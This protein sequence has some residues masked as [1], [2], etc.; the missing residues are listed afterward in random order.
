MS[1]DTVGPRGASPG[2]A[3]FTLPPGSDVLFTPRGQTLLGEIAASRTTGKNALQIGTWL[4]AQGVAPDEAAVLLSQAELRA[5]AVLK[6][7]SDAAHLLFTPAGLEQATRGSVSK[8]HAKRFAAA[9]CTLVADLGCGIGGESLALRAAG[10]GVRAVDIDPLTAR[11][12]AHNLALLSSPKVP[13]TVLNAAAESTDLTGVD[14]IFLDP[15]R[16]TAGHRNTRRLE[17]PDDYSP[18]LSF[19]FALA[20]DFPTGVKLGPGFPRELIPDTAEAQWISVDGQL[21]ETGLWFGKVARP[22]IH[23]A[24][25]VIRGQQHHELTAQAD[26]ADAEERGLGQYLYEPDGAVIRARLIG[27]LA[28]HMNAGM[29][30]AQIAYLTSDTLVATPFTSAFRVIDELPAHEKHLRRALQDRGIGTLEIKKRGVDVDPAALRT[31]LKLRG[32]ESATLILTRAQG[33]HMALLAER[34]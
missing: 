3:R 31:R 13:T 34:C 33:R 5:R 4:R 27:L 1:A 15:A 29:L 32:P 25:L 7:G 11:I 14:G 8:L 24:A 6:F 17:S 16:R 30:S 22:G 26:A 10:I 2:P 19:A 20:H 9:G 23:R 28:E 21:V 18:P 12:A